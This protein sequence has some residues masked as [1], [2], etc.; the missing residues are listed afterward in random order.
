VVVTPPR[1][2]VFPAHVEHEIG[3]LDLSHVTGP[4]EIEGS[5]GFPQ[6]GK[7]KDI[8]GMER[9]AMGNNLHPALPDRSRHLPKSCNSI[10]A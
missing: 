1:D 2:L 7:G 10:R 9:A 8:V 3:S 4:R 5:Q 6:D